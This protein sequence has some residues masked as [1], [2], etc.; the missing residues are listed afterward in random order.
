MILLRFYVFW[1]RLGQR[2]AIHAVG[3][4]GENALENLWRIF[5]ET[6]ELADIANS[7]IY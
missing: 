7:S 6:G 4:V 5:G 2:Y 1:V 3:P